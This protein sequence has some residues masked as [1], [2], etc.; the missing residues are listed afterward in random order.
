MW[1][2][3]SLLFSPQLR[4]SH[5][6]RAPT[7]NSQGLAGLSIFKVQ[8]LCSQTLITNTDSPPCLKQLPSFRAEFWW[9]GYGVH[10]P[11]LQ[12]GVR[13]TFDAVGE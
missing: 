11:D 3:D 13:D 5:A 7:S 10:S 4:C 6:T 12:S 2:C 8:M 9:L 1:V